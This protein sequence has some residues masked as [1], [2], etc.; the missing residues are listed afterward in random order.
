MACHIICWYQGNKNNVLGPII[1]YLFY[2]S[3]SAQNGGKNFVLVAI[4]SD[5]DK[6][7]IEGS[8]GVDH[9]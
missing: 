7:V 9:M 1:D 4:V 3:Q 6:D 2:R 5:V 8:D